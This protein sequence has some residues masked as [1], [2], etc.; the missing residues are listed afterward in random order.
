[1]KKQHLRGYGYI[2]D[3]EA[4]DCLKWHTGSFDSEDFQA[5]GSGL[6]TAIN[7]S[8]SFPKHSDLEQIPK[9]IQKQKKNGRTTSPILTQA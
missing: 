7:A 2:G 4:K 3:K 9:F 6:V 8:F 5:M 1:M